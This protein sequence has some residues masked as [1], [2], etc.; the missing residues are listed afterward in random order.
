[1][2]TTGLEVITVL[3]FVAVFIGKTIARM[4]GPPLAGIMIA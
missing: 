1:M 2:R 3:I 4:L